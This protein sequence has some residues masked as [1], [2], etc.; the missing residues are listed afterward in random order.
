MDKNPIV[1]QFAL[2]ETAAM[3]MGIFAGCVLAHFAPHFIPAVIRYIFG[4]VVGY[5]WISEIPL[6]IVRRGAG[7]KENL[8]E[9]MKRIEKKVSS[10]TKNE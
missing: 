2:Q 1:V 8:P 4:V 5:H 9:W 6:A 7:Y 3:L 10:D